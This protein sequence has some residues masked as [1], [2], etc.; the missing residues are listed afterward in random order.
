MS[1]ISYEV[2]STQIKPFTYKIPLIS[3]ND[4][5]E[6]QATL[7]KNNPSHIKRITFLNLVG[8]NK[9]GEIVSFEPME[10]VTPFLMAHHIDDEKEE[11]DQ[12]SKALVHFFSFLIKLQEKWDKE[13]DE[14]LFDELIDLPRPTW[15]FMPNRKNQRITYQYRVALK[16]SVLE[17][18]EHALRLARS[19][20]S[21]YMRAVTK[22]YSFHLRRGYQFN[23][24]PFAH[25]IITVNYEANGQSMK[26]Y[27]SK[28]VHTTDLRLRFPKSKRNNGEAGEPGRRDLS[29]L[30]NTQWAEVKKILLHTKRVIKN[31]QGQKKFV[32]L[33][34]EYCLFF[35]VC[36][37]TGLRKEEV[38]SLHCGQIAKP[39][40]NKTMLRLGVGAEYGSLTKSKE[41]DNK[42]RRTV[43][44]SDIM[45][46]LYEYT[47][48]TRYQ[49]R[50]AKFKGLCETKREAG[51]DAF[52]ESVDGVDEKKKYVF[53]SHSGIPFFLK[54][55]ELNNRWNEVRNT[56][57]AILGQEMR[58]AIHNLRPTFAVSIFRLLL[59]KM[60]TEK[61]LA[62][63]SELLGHEDLDITIKYLKIAENEPTGD[64]IYEDVLDYMGVFDE[65]N[66]LEEL[67]DELILV[68]CTDA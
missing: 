29:P 28:N 39:P 38:A 36:R 62:A 20:A 11:S 46:L 27:M 64:E 10:E 24:E 48:S 37:F 9:K 53:I 41:G 35:L 16:Y 13:Y 40:R 43:I 50:L 31:V 17:E 22:F 51:E 18:P 60:T 14:D 42:S 54:L 8:R 58:G 3:I 55:N 34:E 65:W 25:E 5:G 23:N 32:Q 45:Q 6:P 33:A 44:P 68:G 26:A 59:Q 30:T 1:E 19:T 63:V 2:S 12:L 4:D 21:A 15:D 52:F 56:V 67:E 47:R 66:E 7:S 57:K 49:K 61:A